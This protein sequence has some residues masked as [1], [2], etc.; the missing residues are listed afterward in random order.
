MP[1]LDHI[2][3]LQFKTK[4]GSIAAAVRKQTLSDFDF[5]TGF[6]TNASLTV[7][8]IYDSYVT[9]NGR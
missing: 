9:I 5:A 1:A 3:A 7:N 4:Y 2:T 8:S 6:G